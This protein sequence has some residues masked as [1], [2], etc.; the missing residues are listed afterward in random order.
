M[1]QFSRDTSVPVDQPPT[2]YTASSMQGREADFINFDSLLSI[3]QGLADLG[4]AQDSKLMNVVHTR[5]RRG[6]L[7]LFRQQITTGTLVEKWK[8]KKDKTGRGFMEVSHMYEFNLTSLNMLQDNPFPYLNEILTCRIKEDQMWEKTSSSIKGGSIKPSLKD[9]KSEEKDT[10]PDGKA[11]DPDKSTK[12]D[13]KDGHDAWDAS[14][15]TWIP[16]FLWLSGQEMAQ[17]NSGRD[18]SPEEVLKEQDS[19]SRLYDE[20]EVTMFPDSIDPFDEDGQY[21]PFVVSRVLADR[22]SSCSTNLKNW[23][24]HNT[25]DYTGIKSSAPVSAFDIAM[26]KN[27]KLQELAK[28]AS[29]NIGPQCTKIEPSKELSTTDTVTNESV[30][31]TLDQLVDQSNFVRR[32]HGNPNPKTR[33]NEC[34]HRAARHP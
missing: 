7:T 29:I 26:A 20:S 33:G 5:A 31:P 22:K 15:V 25:I 1:L 14:K 30:V 9:I 10:K 19:G 16:L 6:L 11:S 21:H 23:K 27:N 17:I 24:A 32:V 12:S 28:S 13:V 3:V 4:L 8:S 34:P 18:I 2:I